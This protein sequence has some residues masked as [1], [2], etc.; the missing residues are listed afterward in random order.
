[1]GCWGRKKKKPT[2]ATKKCKPKRKGWTQ[3]DW[4]KHGRYLEEL[5]IPKK[6]F[7]EEYLRQAPKECKLPLSA[8][9]PKMTRLARPK[10]IFDPKITAHRCH[11]GP[12]RCHCHAADPIRQVSREAQQ[13]KATKRIKMLSQP[14]FD[15]REVVRCFP[16]QGIA[17]VGDQVLPKGLGRLKSLARP[18][19]QYLCFPQQDP[20]AVKPE[21][22]MAVASPRTNMLSKPKPDFSN[23][24]KRK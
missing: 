2:P 17:C 20:F 6:D 19:Y 8:L 10:T 18:K 7:Q 5:S 11:L 22:L 14:K 9:R 12:E 16:K 24:F 3:A 21:A 1:M 23:M 13:Y 15:Y 4:Q